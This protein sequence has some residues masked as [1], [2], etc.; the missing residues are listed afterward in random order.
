MGGESPSPRMSKIREHELAKKIAEADLSKYSLDVVIA[1]LELA[2]IN[3][4]VVDGAQT[5][6]VGAQADTQGFNAFKQDHLRRELYGTYVGSKHY[7]A[8][9]SLPDLSGYS[10]GAYGQDCSIPL[11][12]AVK[13]TKL[14]KHLNDELGWNIISSPVFIYKNIGGKNYAIAIESEIMYAG[15]GEDAQRHLVFPKADVVTFYELSNPEEG[16]DQKEGNTKFVL[17]AMC[18][19]NNFVPEVEMLIAT[20]AFFSAQV[21]LKAIFDPKPELNLSGVEKELQRKRTLLLQPLAN[22]LSVLKHKNITEED[23]NLLAQ[24][25]HESIELVNDPARDKASYSGLIQ[26]VQ[27]KVNTDAQFANN[28][29]AYCMAGLLM[30]A[31]VAFIALAI[32]IFF[33]APPA[34]AAIVAAYSTAQVSSGVLGAGMLTGIAA[35]STFKWGVERRY[36]PLYDAMKAIKKSAEPAQESSWSNWFFSPKP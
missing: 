7:S 27:D 33:F 34:A 24:V 8:Q 12:A 16:S 11:T 36:S 32:A 1:W 6:N 35:G 30:L 26:Q 20:P 18:V 22:A 21:R 15:I 14:G 19:Q 5:F 10:V 17:K 29:I 28:K 2:T 3:K 25:I 31:T 13:A 4:K 23:F 9:D